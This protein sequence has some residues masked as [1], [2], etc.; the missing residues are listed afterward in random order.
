MKFIVLYAAHTLH[1]MV[2]INLIARIV[3]VFSYDKNEAQSHVLKWNFGKIE[4]L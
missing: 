2:Y 1:I 3:C 4:Y